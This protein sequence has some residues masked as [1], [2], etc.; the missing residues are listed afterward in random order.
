MVEGRQ[1][2]I[3]D[4]E[5][6]MADG[7]E[8]HSVSWV[9][10]SEEDETEPQA[11]EV[12]IDIPVHPVAALFPML[13][14]RELDD[15]AADIKGN[16]LHHAIVLDTTGQL[17]DGRNRYVAC[18]RA[19]VKPGFTTL[20]GQEPIA[21]IL[22]QNLAR[23]HMTQG[24]RAV[25]IAM[26]RK[27]AFKAVSAKALASAMGLAESTQNRANVVV[28]N[29]SDLAD[30]VLAG[31]M[32]LPAAYDA[33]RARKE[34]AMTEEAKLRRLGR[35]GPDLAAMV[36]E[37]KLTLASAEME[38]AQRRAASEQKK[39]DAQRYRVGLT[40]DWLDL[41]AKLDPRA[42]EPEANAR[43]WLQCDPALLGRTDDIGAERAR[44]CAD[45][46]LRYAQMK[47]EEDG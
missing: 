36:A 44:L 22:S 19:G 2:S 45:T 8:V 20:N 12:Q 28:D 4:L 26:A 29:A 9:F 6:V 7:K 33:A 23:R 16:G 11:A 21:F 5:G 35:Y 43:Q 14:E 24:Q 13:S 39:V 34:A 42:M 40:Q 3:A 38:L 47:D 46:L 17:I 15:L 32:E 41:L 37:G 31:T 18:A 25:A 27:T 30:A 1:R 10:D